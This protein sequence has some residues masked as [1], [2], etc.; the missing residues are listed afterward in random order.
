MKVEV[1][2]SIWSGDSGPSLGSNCFDL[3]I[4]LRVGDSSGGGVMKRLSH[5]N[6]RLQCVQ[7]YVEMPGTVAPPFE[8]CTS[9]PI[10]DR[11]WGHRKYLG[12]NGSRY[13]MRR[14]VDLGDD[15]LERLT[16]VAQSASIESLGKN[17]QRFNMLVVN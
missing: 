14:A 3:G 16:L 12:R 4:N 6:R 7:A 13:L 17:G 2:R 9:D 8:H 1:S 15:V 11:L 5:P 10:A